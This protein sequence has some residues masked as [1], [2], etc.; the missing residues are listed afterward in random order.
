LENGIGIFVLT[1]NLENIG[2][3]TPE[4]LEQAASRLRHHN[5]EV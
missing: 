1:S 2:V 3:D 5:K 4:D